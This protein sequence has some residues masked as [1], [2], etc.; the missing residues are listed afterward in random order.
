MSTGAIGIIGGT[1][2]LGGAIARAWLE[3]G[4]VAPRELWLANR[5]GRGAG[6]EAWPEVHLTTD[7]QALVERCPVVLLSVLPRD[8]GALRI[9]A[10]DRLLISVMAGVSIEAIAAATHATRI[11]RTLPNAAADLRQSYTPWYAAPGL[12]AGDRDL[13]RRLLDACGASDPVPGEAEI[14]YFTAL[15]GSGPGFVALFAD[16]MIQHAI[17]TGIEPKIAERAVRQLFLGAGAML[18][19]AKASPAETVQGFL[20][21][22]GTTAAG[23]EA[24][25]QSSLQADIGR[26]IEAAHALART[27]MTRS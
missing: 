12:S 18:A 11:V 17:R 22:A 1:G 23:L 4:T 7:N 24:M 14:D 10:K 27:D 9:D 19:L 21:Y 20:D 16:A 5:S 3:T 26:G 2:W 25:Q 13:V 6:F 8:F 15:T